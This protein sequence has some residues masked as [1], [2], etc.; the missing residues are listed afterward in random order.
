MLPVELPRPDLL[1]RLLSLLENQP[2]P[3]AP[4][5]GR[6]FPELL[7]EWVEAR[8]D[9]KFKPLRPRSFQSIRMAC[10]RFKA[11]FGRVPPS[12]LCRE[13]VESVF[14][15]QK[16]SSQSLKNYRSYLSQFFNWSLRR[17]LATTNPLQHLQ[18]ATVNRTVE[19]YSLEQVRTLL[20][21]VQ[22][23]EFVGLVPYLTL[24]LFAG[25]R[26]LE[27]QRMLGVATRVLQ[28]MS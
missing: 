16:W 6:S 21:T 14:T 10:H 8:R 24:G 20:A 23:P 17:G 5:T 1:Q 26:P 22:E 2:A 27:A 25:I 18:V 12:A 19:V 11:L 9:D 3:T 28:S 4:A 13:R 15:R 7:D